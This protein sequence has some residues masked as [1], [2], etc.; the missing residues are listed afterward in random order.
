MLDCWSHGWR[1]RQLNAIYQIIF[2]LNCNP[3]MTLIWLFFI[4]HTHSRCNNTIVNGDCIYE[5]LMPWVRHICCFISP[6][7]CRLSD[8]D[9]INNCVY[10]EHEW[11]SEWVSDEQRMRLPAWNCRIVHCFCS[12]LYAMC[13]VVVCN[14]L[15]GLHARLALEFHA[16]QTHWANTMH[17]YFFFIL[18]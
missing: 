15:C 4:Y 6:Q 9:L 1:I 5:K 12:C 17:D 3:V 11:V 18:I 10:R 2:N 16:T 8:V 13:C 14:E 7:I